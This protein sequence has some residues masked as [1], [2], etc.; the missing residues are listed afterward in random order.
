MARRASSPSLRTRGAASTTAT[1]TPAS[2]TGR[3]ACPSSPAGGLKGSCVDINTY[4]VAGLRAA[5][6][7]AAYLYGYFFPAERG[8]ITNDMHCWVV[9][10]H[11]GRVL[12][13][14][15]AHHMKA[16]HSPV[17]PT[18]D[19][20]PGRRVALGHS[21]GHRYRIGGEWIDVKLLAE[22]MWVRGGGRDARGGPP[23][24]LSRRG[25]EAGPIPGRTAAA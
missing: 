23:R 8:G 3:T 11:A 2:T 7:E 16:G 10:R 5:G 22:P 21:M 6:Y 12:E 17:R 4:L 15:I 19:P 18:L 25:G 24:H 14:D 20:K 9:T 1:R 13:W